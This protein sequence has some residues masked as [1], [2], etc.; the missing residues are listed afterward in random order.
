[1]IYRLSPSSDILLF[2]VK[3]IKWIIVYLFDKYKTR[4]KLGSSSSHDFVVVYFHFRCGYICMTWYGSIHDQKYKLIP[5]GPI[6]KSL[7][8][9]NVCHSQPFESESDSRIC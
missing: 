3:G 9:L 7:N 6:S 8:N 1:M 5:I 4:I 2:C